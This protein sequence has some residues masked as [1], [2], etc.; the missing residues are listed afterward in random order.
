MDLPLEKFWITNNTI[1]TALINT[2]ETLLKLVAQ[3]T[4]PVGRFVSHTFN[5]TGIERQTI[6][7]R[8]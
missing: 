2:T 5:L 1:I 6:A 4:I 8:G 7:F 3:K